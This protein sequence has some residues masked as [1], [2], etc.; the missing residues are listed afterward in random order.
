MTELSQE[1]ILDA[2]QTNEQI[3]QIATLIQTNERTVSSSW[4]RL[5]SLAHKVRQKKY[6]QVY[7]HHSFGAF[8]AS[9]EPKI[10]RKRSQVY[11]CVTVVETLGSQISEEKL[12]EMGI[13]RANELKKYAKES[14]KLVPEELLKTALDPEKDVDNLRAEIAD[15]L[16]KSPDEK[17]KWY[18]FGGFYVTDDERKLIEDTIELAKSIDPVIPHD[19]PEHS[20]KKEVF[21]RLSMEFQSA[22]AGEER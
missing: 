12:E 14:G 20:Q 6:W 3:E 18:D 7:G 19:I 1:E 21:L 11:L 2:Q 8:V 10:K 17:G 9:L 13:S 5:G 15:A 22:Y 16:H 4:V